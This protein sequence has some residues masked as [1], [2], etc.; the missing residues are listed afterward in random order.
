MTFC[1]CVLMYVCLLYVGMHIN[2]CENMVTP[3]LLV[4]VCVCV[5]VL[6]CVCV[7]VCVSVCVCMVC[8]VKYLCVC[9]SL[10][11]AA[12]GRRPAGWSR[13]CVC[14]GRRAAWRPSP[15]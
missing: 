2:I 4:C 3:T 5:C 6:V 12:V 14:L 7:C 15:A 1:V 11:R 8:V 9:Y 10:C 13:T